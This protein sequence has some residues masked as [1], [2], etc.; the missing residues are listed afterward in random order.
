MFFLPSAAES[1]GPDGFLFDRADRKSQ[2]LGDLDLGKTIEAVQ[3]KNLLSPW[4]Q[5]LQRGEQGMQPLTRVNH[6]IRE[7]LVLDVLFRKGCPR[8]RV[9]DTLSPE[10]VQCQILGGPEEQTMVRRTKRSIVQFDERILRDIFGD[11]AIADDMID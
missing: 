6:V 3:E 11:R 2:D 8:V 9:A 4:G 1:E 5:R 10:M 7:G